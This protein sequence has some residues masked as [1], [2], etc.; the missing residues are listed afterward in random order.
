MMHKGKLFLGFS[1]AA[2]IAVPIWLFWTSLFFVRYPD[3]FY[4]QADVISLDNFYDEKEKAFLG[5]QISKTKFYYEMVS[6]ENTVLT[7]RNVFDVRKMTGEKIF[8]VK[9]LY[10]IDSKT[11]RHVTGYGD[12]DRDGYLSAPK[13]LRKQGYVYWHINY[14][15]PAYLM[16]QGQQVIEG[17][18]VYRYAVHYHADQTADLGFLPGVPED[19]GVNLDIHLQTWIEPVSGHLVKYKDDT[20]AYYYDIK[21]KERIEPWNKF[22]NSYSKTSV[23]EQV[24]TAK[25]WKYRIILNERVIPISLMLISAL[26]LIISIYLKKKSL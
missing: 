23:K 25:E 12:Q 5:A 20:T 13:G 24:E 7:I 16:F 10:G 15:E 22:S 4:Y 19:R 2:L 3:N 9:R 17:L 6:K 21:T 18:K 26:F 8:I 1:M 14:D 11:G